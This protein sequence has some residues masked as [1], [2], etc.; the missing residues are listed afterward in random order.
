MITAVD[1]NIVIDL[2]ARGSTSAAS[3][4]AALTRCTAEGRVVIGETA[5]VEIAT[6]L[7]EASDAGRVIDTLGVAFLP[8]TRDATFRAAAAW[9]R[10]RAESGRERLMPDFLIGGHA[11]AQADRLLT[12]DTA[13]FRRWFPELAVVDPADL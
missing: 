3:S 2:L 13:F 9:R 7:P 1:A 6:G 5:L 8:S 10:A 11:L 12:R 4:S